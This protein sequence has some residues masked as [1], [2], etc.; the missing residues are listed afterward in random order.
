MNR[1]HWSS[2]FYDPWKRHT[3]QEKTR[4]CSSRR[5]A[6]NHQR[7]KVS[8]TWIGASALQTTR[9][10]WRWR[11]SGSCPIGTSGISSAD[12]LVDDDMSPAATTTTTRERETMAGCLIRVLPL[13]T[14]GFGG[15][16]GCRIRVKS[17]QVRIVPD[18]L[19]EGPKIN[20]SYI[21]KLAF[22]YIFLYFLGI[23]NVNLMNI[24]SK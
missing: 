8:L 6:S 16:R 13:W 5:C 4:A 15:K 18:P 2:F 20:F 9:V 12:T 14:D 22:V 10:R 1:K 17:K 21:G 19:C 23:K 11:C 3:K 7:I 24:Y